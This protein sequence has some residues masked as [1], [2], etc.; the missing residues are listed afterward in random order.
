MPTSGIT[1]L[2]ERYLKAMV[3]VMVGHRLSPVSIAVPTTK[4]LSDVLLTDLEDKAQ[5]QATDVSS[6]V[7]TLQRYIHGVYAGMENGYKN[8]YFD[9]DDQDY[10]W[11]ILSNYSSWSAN[12]LLK[13]HAANYIEPSL[14][15]NKTELFRA[16]EGEVMQRRLTDASVQAAL[17]AYTSSFEKL[18]NLEVRSGYIDGTETRIAP[19]FLV[20]RSRT[21][22]FDHYLRKVKVEVDESSK[23]INPAN[24]DEW[25]KCNIDTTGTVIDIRCVLW[26]GQLALVWCEWIDRQVDG[27]GVVQS[28]WNLNIKLAFK[29]VDE[30][31]SAPLTLHSRQC[32]SDVSDGWLAVFS[33]GDASPNDDRLRVCYTNRHSAD[34]SAAPGGIEIHEVRDHLMRKVEGDISTSLAMVF[35]RFRN[36]NGVQQ[37]VVPADYPK[38]EIEPE[39]PPTDPIGKGQWVDV[40]FSREMLADGSWSQVLRVR[41]R[42]TAVREAGRVLQRLSI[43]WRALHAGTYTDVSL[44]HAD[45]THIT[46]TLTTRRKP[47]V[48]HNVRLPKGNAEYEIVHPFTVADFKETSEGDGIWEAQA[49]AALKDSALRYLVER[50]SEEIRAG[51][52]FT[53]DALDATVVNDDNR[54]EQKVLYNA[55]PFSIGLKNASV[56]DPAPS[57]FTAPLDGAVISPWVVYTSPVFPINAGIPV[58]FSAGGVNVTFI[59]KLTDQPKDYLTPTIGETNAQG[60]QFLSFND[61]TQ[62]LKHLRLNSQIGA[63]LTSRA[64]LSVDALLDWDTQHVEEDPLPDG[65]L[66]PNGPFDGCNG[67]Y[68]WELFFHVPH[69]VFWRLSEEGRYQEA[70]RWLEYIFHPLSPEVLER[71]GDLKA[72]AR[73]AYWRC[74]PLKIDHIDCS[75]EQLAPTDPDAL[76]YCA[77]I[78]FMIAIFLH[79]VQNLIA[80]G[81][82]LFRRLDYDSMVRAGLV[83]S[84]AWRM[85][86]EKIG[87]DTASTWK[88]Q[89]LDELLTAIKSRDP[90]KAFEA[91]LKLSLADIPLSMKGKPRLDLTGSGV[92]KPG[93]N[94][95]PAALWDLLKSRLDN[96]R[97]NRSIDGYAL[98]LPL[99]PPMGDPRQLL[100][101]QGNGT[102]G[103]SRNPGGQMQ[104]VPYRFQ[105]VYE[106]AREAVEFLIQQEDQ[107]RAWLEMRDRNKLEELQHEHL[108]ELADH[109]RSIHQATIAQLE[110]TAASLRQSESMVNERVEHFK[111][112]VNDGVSDVENK[113]IEKNRAARQIATGAAALETVGAGLRLLPNMFGTSFGGVDLSAV[114]YTGAQLLQLVAQQ[115]RGEAEEASINEAYRRRA[116][117]WVFEHNQSRAQ[118]RVLREQIVAQEHGIRAARASLEQSEMANTQSKAIYRFYKERSTGPDL[119]NWIV[120]QI[121]TLLYQVN[122]LCVS[123][124]TNAER[125]LQ[126]ETGDFKTNIIRPDAWNDTRHGFTSG[127]ALK[128]G[129]LQLSAARV[130]RNER[131]MEMT[132]TFSLRQLASEDEWNKFIESGSLDFSLKE[133]HFADDYPQLYCRQVVELTCTCPGLLGPYENL[134]AT[135]M[136]LGSSTMLAPSIATFKYL[137]D[138]SDE[139]PSGSLVQNLRPYQ[140]IGLSRGVDDNGIVDRAPSDRLLPFEGTGVHGEYKVTFPR[141]ARESQANLLQ[142]LTDFLLTVSYRA[143][144][145]GPVFGAAVEAV[146]AEPRQAPKK[147]V[148]IS[149]G[150]AQP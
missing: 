91:R 74:R 27:N 116:E 105:T 1:S 109:T 139:P 21:Q 120:G 42:C 49:V 25:R 134:C 88:S 50:T 137:H 13:N 60:A 39:N 4:T 92:F 70:Q 110:A 135:L 37:K 31:W 102:L 133:S 98:A 101:A 55:V 90:L 72:I 81:D 53:V 107:L 115:W 145:G 127:A 86:G 59:V 97:S 84:K 26:L 111:R 40:V 52:G 38:I 128:M 136:Q 77:P 66:E 23:K 114:P 79:Y 122:D 147:R 61:P 150:K 149:A 94:E 118:A 113:V 73:P 20:A 32:E 11:K 9:P 64:A 5:A 93:V 36:R 54:L 82:D 33:D 87:T 129:L 24:W 22:P 35:G 2:K 141:P 46:I 56:T 108:I 140:Q 142:S 117:E 71:R 104:V 15:L 123:L 148:A 58:D 68:F 125:A 126:Y 29:S 62:A 119:S 16:L 75:S 18:S 34:R 80:E 51:A 121:K 130:Q 19:Y 41:G 7:R 3:D 47:V 67:R 83:Y 103:S 69:M 10:W 100:I 17:M 45:D 89:T 131:Q 6:T 30:T 144:D 48:V 57:Q 106:L 95:R 12:V 99:F 8:V 76:G 96:L 146:L 85:I 138:G 14:R 63:I 43:R 124:C 65:T 28:P 112:L 44:Q 78:H 143:R 132:K